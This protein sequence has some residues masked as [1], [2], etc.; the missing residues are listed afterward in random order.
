[1]PS[2]QSNQSTS[3]GYG[4]K[5]DLSKVSNLKTPAPNAYN[6]SRDFDDQGNRIL[7]SGPSFGIGREVQNIFILKICDK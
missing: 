5:Y 7:N 2:I 3:F 6:V 4:Q 1:L